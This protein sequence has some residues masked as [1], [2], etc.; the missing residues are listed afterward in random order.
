MPNNLKGSTPFFL[1]AKFAEAEMMKALVNAG[2]DRRLLPPSGVTPLLVAAGL[3]WGAQRPDSLKGAD[4]RGADY[5]VSTN[6]GASLRDQEE[7]D[8]FNAVTFLLD[9]GADPNET[10]PNGN[11]PLMG[12]VPKGFDSVV[13]LLVEHGADVNAKNKRGQTALRLAGA[14]QLKSTADLLRK[15]GATDN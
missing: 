9:I 1:A 12:A 4:R 13:R 6:Y 7:R 3:G 8:T 15:L 2:A 10:D 14:P 5:G 11:T